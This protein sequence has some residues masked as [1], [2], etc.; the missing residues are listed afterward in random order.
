MEQVQKDRLKANLTSMPKM[1]SAWFIT[2]T[3]LLTAWWLGLDALEQTRYLQML[4]WK[5][6]ADKYPLLLLVIGLALRAWPQTS[7]TPPTP[8]EQDT[9]PQGET[10]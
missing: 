4:P 3:G 2:L 6:S 9:L 8:D 7:L 1:L 5:L 10:P